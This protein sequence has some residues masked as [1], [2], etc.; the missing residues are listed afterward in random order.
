[1]GKWENGKEKIEMKQM[2]LFRTTGKKTQH[3]YIHKFRSNG[4]SYC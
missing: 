2:L 1:M 3:I 4:K